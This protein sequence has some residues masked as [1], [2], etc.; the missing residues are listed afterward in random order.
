MKPTLYP[1][2][3]RALPPTLGALV[4]FFLHFVALIALLAFSCEPAHAFGKKPVA[5][6][7]TPPSPPTPVQPPTSS[8]DVIRARWEPSVPEGPAWSTYVF[9]E[10]PALAPNLLA[11]APA[12][13]AGFCPGYA[14]LSAT[15]QKNF[16][17]Y[18]VSSI[19]QLESDF[20]P[21]SI[22]TENF[23]DSSGNLVES[24]GLLQLSVSDSPNY[25]CGFST[26]TDVETPDKNL[27]CGLRILNKWVGADGVISARSGSSWRGGARYWSTLRSAKLAQI[28]GWTRALAICGGTR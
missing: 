27:A 15:D 13:I 11:Q 28:Q 7:P 21:S 16:W 20:D 12:D 22:Y 17:V 24:V 18:L 3:Q 10:L 26:T 8:A 23:R 6:P 25:H 19:A 2:L 1:L 5:V 9:S 14:N 4:L